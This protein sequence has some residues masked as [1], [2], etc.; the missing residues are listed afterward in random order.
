MCECC[1]W[2]A[3]IWLDVYLIE[4]NCPFRVVNTCKMF[5][6]RIKAL[7]RTNTYS[8][9]N[10]SFNSAVY[11]RCRLN[12]LM[13]V[14]WLCCVCK[15]KT[16]YL[17]QHNSVCFVCHFSLRRTTNEF[18]VIIIT[19]QYSVVIKLVFF[20]LCFSLYRFSLSFLS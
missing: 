15:K 6:K 12:V 13:H 17:I 14:L 8:A 20:S 11:F 9:A 5:I 18:S 16:F 7:S 4:K 2:H 1:R 19:M 10:V 3:G